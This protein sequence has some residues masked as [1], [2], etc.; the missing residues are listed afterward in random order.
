MERRWRSRGGLAPHRAMHTQ[1]RSNA[2]SPSEGGLAPHRAMRPPCDS[3][4]SP[5]RNPNGI[6]STSPGLRGT[7]YPGN[8]SPPRASTLKGLNQG[9]GVD[10]PS[11]RVDVH[12]VKFPR[13]LVPHYLGLVDLDPLAVLSSFC[14]ARSIQT[15]WPPAARVA[16]TSR[17]PF[18][19]TLFD[20]RSGASLRMTCELG[21]K[22]ARSATATPS[23]R[24]ARRR[25]RSRRG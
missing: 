3:R 2:P 17:D 25:F 21:E 20:S 7:S 12:R 8:R 24:S 6:Q 16:R 23:P 11:F 1:K 15:G 5:R 22:A 10:A 18:D 4:T 9:V 19:G 13:P 14:L